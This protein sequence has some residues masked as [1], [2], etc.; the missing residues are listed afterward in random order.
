MYY[1]F[2]YICCRVYTVT[3]TYKERYPYTQHYI[4][5]VVTDLLP[6]CCLTCIGIYLSGMYTVCGLSQNHHNNKRMR[7]TLCIN[8]F[9][10]IQ[11]YLHIYT[12]HQENPHTYSAI[13]IY[14]KFMYVTVSQDLTAPRGVSH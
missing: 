1:F 6:E 12:V 11:T 9:P 5:G 14:P 4:P 13:L 2:Y 8:R 10:D 7:T 3:Q